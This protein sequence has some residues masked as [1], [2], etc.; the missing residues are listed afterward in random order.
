[1]QLPHVMLE[2]M[3]NIVFKFQIDYSLNAEI[4]VWVD[5]RS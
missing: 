5:S 4:Y 1:M 2:D 3:R